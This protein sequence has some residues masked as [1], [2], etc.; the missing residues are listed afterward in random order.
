MVNWV[1]DHCLCLMIGG[2]VGW[3]LHLCPL[4]SNGGAECPVDGQKCERV[5]ACA[6]DACVCDV[7]VCDDA[8]CGCPNCVI[9]E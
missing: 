1:K 7:C 2:V 4:L 5:T 8:G 6:C 9:K 3:C